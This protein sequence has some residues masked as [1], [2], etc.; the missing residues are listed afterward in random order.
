MIKR[1]VSLGEMLDE[2]QKLASASDDLDRGSRVSPP[3]D[4]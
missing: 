2:W 4:G 3:R 1:I